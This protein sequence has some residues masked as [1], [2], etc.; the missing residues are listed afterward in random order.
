MT[1]K[2][3][4]AQGSV[5]SWTCFFW[6]GVSG[7]S[8]TQ[9]DAFE[10]YSKLHATQRCQKGFLPSKRLFLRYS[11]Q[12]FETGYICKLYKALHV[13]WT[14]KAPISQCCVQQ[15]ANFR[16]RTL[17]SNCTTCTTDVKYT[18]PERTSRVMQLC[19]RIYCSSTHIPYIQLYHLPVDELWI[20]MSKGGALDTQSS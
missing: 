20:H 1:E 3:P 18:K 4:L 17:W 13:S 8:L 19:G 9:Q 11:G 2:C 5:H 12:T 7:T 14:R 6:W 10:R 16:Q 15:A